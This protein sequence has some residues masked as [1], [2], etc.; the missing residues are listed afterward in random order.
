MR[1]CVVCSILFDPPAWVIKKSDIRCGECRRA[2]NKAWRLKR[3]EAGT[4]VKVTKMPREHVKAYEAKRL[5]V[6]GVRERRNEQMRG[7]AKLEANRPRFEARW[8]VGRALT[9]G[10]LSRLPCEVCGAT[11]A[12][13]HHDDYS[14]P[15][16]VRWLCRTHHIE[17]HVAARK[18]P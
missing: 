18:L 7:Y 11:N 10:R 13:A 14:Q 12:Q 9:S 1:H 2:S 16:S 3:K 6:P 15:L 8:Q 5:A 4:P 17:H